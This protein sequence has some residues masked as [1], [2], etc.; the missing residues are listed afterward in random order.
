LV[1]DWYF[2]RVVGGVVHHVRR[3]VFLLRRAFS[4]AGQ[5]L[6]LWSEDLALF[7]FGLVVVDAPVGLNAP[8]GLH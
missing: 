1:K 5:E 3:V 8:V 7:G 4:L 6:V 2:L